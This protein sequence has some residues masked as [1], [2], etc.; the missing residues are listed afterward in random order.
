MMNLALAQIL[1]SFLVVYVKPTGSLYKIT[2]G[3]SDQGDQK[4]FL[5]NVFSHL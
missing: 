2:K 1:I 4:T 5:N 3:L